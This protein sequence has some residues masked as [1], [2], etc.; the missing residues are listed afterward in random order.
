MQSAELYATQTILFFNLL[1]IYCI[2][3]F[4]CNI[5]FLECLKKTSNSY[6]NK[7]LHFIKSDIQNISY[8]QW[9]SPPPNKMMNQWLVNNNQKL[10]VLLSLL[11][12][13]CFH[14][15]RAGIF[16]PDIL[17]K[18]SR[19]IDYKSGLW[20]DSYIM[21]SLGQSKVSGC[22]VKPWFDLPV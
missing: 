13:I 17:N 4:I 3:K 5:L 22:I 18:P 16:V 20:L 10:W 15:A 9:S 6:C 7:N 8:R 2:V 14:M 11:I 21:E 19:I 12:S 1:F